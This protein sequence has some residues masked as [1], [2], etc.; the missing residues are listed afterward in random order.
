VLG[1]TEDKVVA[2]D[3]RGES[4]TSVF[5]AEAGIA[6]DKTFVKVV[7]WYDN[8]WGYS[9][10]CLEMARVIA[11][12]PGG[13]PDRLNHAPVPPGP[14]AFFLASKRAYPGDDRAVGHAAANFPGLDWRRL[15]SLAGTET[16]H[17]GTHV[18]EKHAAGG[19]VAD[20]GPGA[21]PARATEAPMSTGNRR[22][23][24]TPGG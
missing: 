17:R 21:A 10:K 20:R 6:L 12:D 14:G 18:E 7:A 16:F 23:A 13:R 3:F 2:T 5:D 9:N 11:K 22:A 15:M 1:Y 24:P 4:C 8:E 19:A